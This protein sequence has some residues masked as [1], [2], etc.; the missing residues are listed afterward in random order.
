[1]NC[2]FVSPGT[3]I[4]LILWVCMFIRGCVDIDTDTDT[5]IDCIKLSSH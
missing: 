3:D 4:I 5:G 1:M 2:G